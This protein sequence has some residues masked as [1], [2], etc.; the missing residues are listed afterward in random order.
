MRLI[1]ILVYFLFTAG[2]TGC[3]ILY[4]MAVETTKRK[5]FT[6]LLVFVLSIFFTPVIAWVGSM[7]L[8]AKPGSDGNASDPPTFSGLFGGD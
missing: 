7:A 1:D 4:W 3:G 2:A 8:K 6:P 5:G